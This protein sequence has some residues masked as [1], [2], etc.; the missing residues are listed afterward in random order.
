MI[1][2][3]QQKK[4]KI[5]Y[6]TGTGR[7]GSTLLNRLLDLHPRIFGVGEI[8]HLDAYYM[9]NDLCSCGQ[10]VRECPIWSRVVKKGVK[11]EKITTN[12]S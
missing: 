2:I 6:I 4:I 9:H 8:F 12:L 11:P 3:N 10:P 5:L 7:S 1:T